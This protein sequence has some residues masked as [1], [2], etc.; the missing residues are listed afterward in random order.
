MELPRRQFLQGAVGVTA[1]LLIPH[2]AIAQSYPSKPTRLIVGFPPGGPGDISARLEGQWL[3]ERFGKPFVVENR[4]GAG[5]NVGTEIVVHAPPDGYT[6]FLV[7]TANA[8]NASLYEHLSFDFLRDIAPVAGIIR[9]PNVMEVNSSFPAKTVSEFI[10]YARQNPGKVNY[11]SSGNGTLTH[12]SAELFKMMTSI[13][14]VHVP[15]RGSG[16]AVAALLGG[17]V[18][19]MFD[20]VPSSIEHIRTGKLTPLAV[21]SSTRSAALPDV[22]ALAEFVPGYEATGWYGIGTPRDT[23][24]EIIET[25]NKAVNAGSDDSSMKTRFADLGGIA[26]TGSV[27]D[28]TSLIAADARKWAQ[29]VQF[30]G[31]KP[32]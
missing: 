10:A 24:A 20:A 2:P 13:D 25:L 29:V 6:L 15:Y 8:I 7:N 21:S 16:P 22:P 27:A 12:V 11:A 31:A 19:V 30:C 14:M 18:Q 9:A 28:F 23:P 1:A 4:P 26:L 32:D 5:G 3:A 17:D